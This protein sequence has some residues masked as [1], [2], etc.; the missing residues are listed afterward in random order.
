[1]KNAHLSPDVRE[2]LARLERG[3]KQSLCLLWFHYGRLAQLH[4]T[5]KARETLGEESFETMMSV[6]SNGED[7]A[8]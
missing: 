2:D 6:F 4:G 1:M 8:P 5:A 7:S 3:F